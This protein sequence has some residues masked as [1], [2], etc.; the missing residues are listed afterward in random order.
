M[1]QGRSFEQPSPEV[2]SQPAYVVTAHKEG[3]DGPLWKKHMLFSWSTIRLSKNSHNAAQSLRVAV[4]FVIVIVIGI[5]FF[6][7][8]VRFIIFLVGLL[9]KNRVGIYQPIS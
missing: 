8:V 1:S 2:C 3:P 9:S 7:V 4:A 5:F 6:S